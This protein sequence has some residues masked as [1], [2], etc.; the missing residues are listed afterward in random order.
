MRKL[1]DSVI[2]HDLLGHIDIHL[3]VVHVVV[4]PIVTAGQLNEWVETCAHG[5]LRQFFV[6]DLEIPFFTN[7]CFHLGAP[8]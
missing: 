6:E 7:K 3:L 8:L 1:L 2:P 4:R 5:V